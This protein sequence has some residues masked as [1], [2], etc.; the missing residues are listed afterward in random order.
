M[1]PALQAASYQPQPQPGMRRGGV[2]GGANMQA[3]SAAGG[4]MSIDP[5]ALQGV[6]SNFVQEFSGKLTELTGPITTMGDSLKGIADSLSGLTMTHSFT[7]EI[8]MSVNIG[9]KDAIVTAVKEGIMPSIS[10]LIKTTI[11][12]SGKE[13]NTNGSS[14]PPGTP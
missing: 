3:A 9:N 10:E 13:V 6:L 11:A 14:T 7:G 4:G 8:G 2:V 1:N 12:N 5:T